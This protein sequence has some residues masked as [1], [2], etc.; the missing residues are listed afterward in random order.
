MYTKL[1][2]CLAKV[3]EA[4]GDASAEKAYKLIRETIIQPWEN[5]RK[6]T[7]NRFRPWWNDTLES[8]PKLR[9]KLYTKAL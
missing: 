6:R 2:E 4:N 8:M 1:P 7:P 3:I 5:A 9:R